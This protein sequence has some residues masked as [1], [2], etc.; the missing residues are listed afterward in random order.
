[1]QIIPSMDNQIKKTRLY[2]GIDVGVNTGFA[3]YN[4][5]NKSFLELS[6]YN[7]WDTIEKLDYYIQQVAYQLENK[8]E[9]IVILEDVTGNRPTF[10][11]DI[12]G[13][14]DRARKAREKISQNVGQNKRDYILIREYLL[15]KKIAVNSVTPN[16]NSFTKLTAESFNNITK[17]KGKTT[18]HSRDAGMLCYGRM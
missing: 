15:R 9:L 8:C 10:D 18:S 5:C 1:M 11:H 6:T 16:I 3:V 12:T 13:N 2:I 17:Y 4:P 7:F 14:T